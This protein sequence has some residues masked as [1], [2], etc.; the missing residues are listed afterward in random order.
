MQNTVIGI[1]A[2][3]IA[4]IHNCHKSGNAEWIARHTAVVHMLQKK[5]LPSGSGVD[6]GVTVNLDSSQPDDIRMFLG[7]HHMDEHGYYTEWTQ[8]TVR[9]RP[10]FIGGFTIH[11]NGRDYNGIKDYLHEILANAFVLEVAEADIIEAQA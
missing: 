3:R 9:V 8:H 2:A 11:I 7:Y 10:S 1:L 4:A 5:Y 6:R